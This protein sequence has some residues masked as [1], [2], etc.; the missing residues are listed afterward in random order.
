MLHWRGEDAAGLRVPLPARRARA[1]VRQGVDRHRLE[2]LLRELGVEARISQQVLLAGQL[3]RLPDAAERGAHRAGAAAS[4]C[5][6]SCRPATSPARAPRSPRCRCA[7]APRPRRSCARSS[8]SSFRARRLQ[9]PLHRPAG[10]PG[11]SGARRRRRLRGAR[12][13]RALDRP[14]PRLGRRGRASAALLHNRP[15][16]S[17]GGRRGAG[18]PRRGRRGLRG[19]RHLRRAGRRAGRPRRASGWRASTATT[20]SAR[21]E[22][23]RRSTRSRAPTS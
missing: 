7:S 21:D 6:G 4:P 5:R 3:R 1:S 10:L 12:L 14:A 2:I 18:H 22:V 9:R 15:S 20:C 8:T 13:R 16:R 17:R 19:L 11:M 23:A